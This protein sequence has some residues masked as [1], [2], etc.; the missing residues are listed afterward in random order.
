MSTSSNTR[1]LRAYVADLLQYPRWI[2]EHEVDFTNCPHD[3]HYNAFLSDCAHC[4][5]ARG[6]RWLDRQRTPATDDASLEELVQALEGAVAYLQATTRRLALDD[7]E[8][9]DW[10]REARRFLRHRREHG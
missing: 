1:T 8:L 5:F 2:I 7:A 3:S 10:M 4:R 9:R 6:C